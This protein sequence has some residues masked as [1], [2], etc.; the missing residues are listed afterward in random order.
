MT[1]TEPRSSRGSSIKVVLA[2]LPVLLILI[3]LGTWQLDRLAWKN[4]L[5]A[6]IDAGLAADPV[7]LPGLIDNAAHWDYVRVRVTGTF[8]HDRE[9][10]IGPRLY[11]GPDGRMQAG[12]H[13]L[14][15]LVRGDGGGVVLVDRGWVPLDRRDPASRA[16]GQ[17]VG[18]VTVTG[19]GRKPQDRGFMQPDN[20]PATR[21]FFWLDMPALAGMAGAVTLS[22][23]VVQADNTAN[24]GGLPIG[25]R[26]I[27]SL[28]NDHLSYALTWYGLALTLIGVLVAAGWRRRRA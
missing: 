4:D 3:G 1:R 10:Y 28:K 2:A 26:T 15:P 17:V 13:V 16:N 7:E 22:P 12:V 23:V 14:T 8:L 18:P 25:G 19:I 24:P 6:R 5:I 27:V 21:E 9:A 11:P 20:R